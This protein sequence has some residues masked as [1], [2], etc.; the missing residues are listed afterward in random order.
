MVLEMDINRDGFK[1][2]KIESHLPGMS[3]FLFMLEVCLEK[4]WLICLVLQSENIEIENTGSIYWV[5]SWAGTM[6]ASATIIN[7]SFS[8]FLVQL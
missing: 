5:P 6:E 8:F 3:L 4:T 2:C 7:L 1:F